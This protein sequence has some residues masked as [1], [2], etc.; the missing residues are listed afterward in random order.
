MLHCGSISLSGCWFISV[1]VVALCFCHFN[2]LYVIGGSL[3]LSRVAVSWTWCHQICHIIYIPSHRWLVSVPI[4]LQHLSQLL[5]HFW[6][7][8]CV[9]S[10]NVL[11]LWFVCAG[12]FCSLGGLLGWDVLRIVWSCVGFTGLGQEARLLRWMHFWS[13]DLHRLSRLMLACLLLLLKHWACL[14]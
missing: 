13:H 8:I 6:L 2:V 1:L 14:L 4:C 10:R 7:C 3:N 5:A 11:G 12:I 9:R